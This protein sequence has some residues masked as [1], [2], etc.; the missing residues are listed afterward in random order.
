M[1][2]R[3]PVVIVRDLLVGEWDASNTAYPNQPRVHTGW[4]DMGSP[5]PQVTVTNPNEGPTG[6]GDTGYTH[7]DGAGGVGQ[8]ITGTCLVNGWAGTREDLEGEAS[9]G[10]DINPKVLAWDFAK[11][12]A[13]ILSDYASGT[14]DPNSGDLE[15][16]FV[17]PGEA[18]R[19]VDTDPENAVFRY[20]V[21]ARYGYD[22]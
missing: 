19:M 21:T 3:E 18:R 8:L 12:I 22:R 4:Y 2:E 7:M 15:L 9:D 10:S 14:N 20:E 1:I 6:G 5:N 11:E 16:S 17:A 13:R